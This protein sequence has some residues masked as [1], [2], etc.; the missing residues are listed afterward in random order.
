MRSSR[1]ILHRSGVKMTM[2]RSLYF[3]AMAITLMCRA[4]SAALP[5]DANLTSPTLAIATDSIVL[6]CQRGNGPGEFHWAPPSGGFP[7]GLWPRCAAADT[8][9]SIYLLNERPDRV[10]IL[11]FTPDGTYAEA[12]QLGNAE[13]RC[14]TADS[15]SG[16]WIALLPFDTAQGM[17]TLDRYQVRKYVPGGEM[18]VQLASTFDSVRRIECLADGTVCVTEYG[19]DERTN[20]FDPEGKVL[21][22]GHTQHSPSSIK[23]KLESSLTDDKAK[24]TAAYRHFKQF[25]RGTSGKETEIGFGPD[26]CLYYLAVYDLDE[27][28]APQRISVG[29]LTFRATESPVR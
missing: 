6:N 25:P 12:I 13:V 11:R 5:G 29:K 26:G 21:P 20:L 17:A 4:V 27:N 14:M 15:R 7:R 22:T 28:R 18:R 10:E 3:L 16:I 24:R 9:G 8:S 19:T 1:E 2:L 23:V